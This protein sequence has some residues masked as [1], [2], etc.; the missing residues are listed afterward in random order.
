MLP[1]KKQAK[2]F[3]ALFTCLL[4]AFLALLGCD[5]NPPYKLDSGEQ[6]VLTEGS[7]SVACSWEN[8][9]YEVDMLLDDVLPYTAKKDSSQITL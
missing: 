1:K 9:L 5:S 6:V 2:L 3:S 8:L 4:V 7:S